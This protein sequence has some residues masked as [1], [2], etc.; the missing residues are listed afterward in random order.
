VTSALS[1]TAGGRLNIAEID[2]SDQLGTALNGSH[3][4]TR[5]NPVVG[6]A[7]KITPTLTAYA[8]YSE[9]NRAPI[10]SELACADPNRPCLL[11][12][13]L[14]ADP[15]LKQ[16]VSHTY[17]AGLRGTL[18]LGAVPGRIGW[19]AGAFHTVNSDD[20]LS[21]P[22]PIAGRGYFQN[23]GG[24]QRQGIELSARYQADRWSAFAGYSLIDATFL[25]TITLSSPFNP[26]ADA[27]GFITVRPGDRIPGIPRHRFKAGGEYSVT[28]AWKVGVDVIAVSSQYLTG[29]EANLNAPLP[30]YWV[31]N[32]RTS[33]KLSEHAEAFGLV[34]N[35]FDRRY[36]TFGRFFDTAAIPFLGLTDPRTV[37]PGAPFAVYGGLKFGL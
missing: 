7:Y 13:F 19:S 36:Y 2:L 31:A 5:F 33:Y 29:D 37:S 20:I 3:R 23:I 26:F 32:L 6:A 11:D 15:D 34:Q 12:N 17:E 10:P 1:V 8:G 18:E 4:F 30:G 28:D 27:D 21:V 14:V 9:A 35:L 16:V 22:S 25:D 24:T